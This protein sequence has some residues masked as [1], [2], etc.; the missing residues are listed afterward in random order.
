MCSIPIIALVPVVALPA[1]VL[2]RVVGAGSAPWQVLPQRDRI[3]EEARE[4]TR[5]ER[6]KMEATKPRCC[7]AF[8]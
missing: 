7:G 2:L 3:L 4:I 6:L 5:L 8:C 1:V